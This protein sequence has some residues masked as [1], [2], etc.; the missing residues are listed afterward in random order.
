M[1][2]PQRLVSYVNLSLHIPEL[3][4]IFLEDISSNM[5]TTYR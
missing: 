5:P 3:T 1:L 4:V 2:P